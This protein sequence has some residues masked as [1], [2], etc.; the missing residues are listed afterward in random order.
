MWTIFVRANGGAA[1]ELISGDQEMIE[2]VWESLIKFSSAHL[3]LARSDENG[4]NQHV[5]TLVNRQLIP[6]PEESRV[7]TRPDPVKVAR[8]LFDDLDVRF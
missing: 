3:V 8:P 1:I 5:R 2:A 4:T 6:P 7:P